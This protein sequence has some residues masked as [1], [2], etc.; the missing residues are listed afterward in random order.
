MSPEGIPQPK[1]ETEGAPASQPHSGVEST[2][3]PSTEMNPR[4]KD[5]QGLDYWAHDLY[6]RGKISRDIYEHFI[7][8]NSHKEAEMEKRGLPQLEHYG[9]FGSIEGIEN[10]LQTQDDAQRFIIRCA[11]GKGDIKRKLNSTKEEVLEYARELPGGFDTWK[12]E[13]K[14][15]T[16]TK[17]AGTLIIDSGGNVIME[18]WQGPHYFVSKG[19]P[20]ITCHYSTGDFIPRYTWNIPNGIDRHTGKMMQERMLKIIKKFAPSLRPRAREPLYLEYGIKP[21]NSF[22]AIEANDSVLLTDKFPEPE[23]SQRDGD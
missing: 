12:V 10:F 4:T 9:Y 16:E 23:P 6:L 13:L 19:Y 8:I 22:Y 3:T 18:S 21:D 17:E 2:A 20:K 1:I 7:Y 11:N 5:G 14:E 15:F